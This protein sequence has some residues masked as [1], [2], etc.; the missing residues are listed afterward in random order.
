MGGRGC[1]GSQEMGFEPQKVWEQVGEL[2]MLTDAAEALAVCLEGSKLL[3][4]VHTVRELLSQGVSRKHSR[5]LCLLSR[6]F[7]G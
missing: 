7:S 1:D 3:I 4:R 6:P 2:G 5:A